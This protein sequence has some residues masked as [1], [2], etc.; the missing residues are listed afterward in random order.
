[1]KYLLIFGFLN[2]PYIYFLDSAIVLE[3]I[4]AMYVA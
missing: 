4:Y 2:K 3:Y 1:M